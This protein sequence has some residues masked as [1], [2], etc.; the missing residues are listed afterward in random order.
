M[1]LF[2]TGQTRKTPQ[3]MKSNRGSKGSR[4]RRMEEEEEDKRRRF[5]ASSN[6]SGWWLVGG[7]DGW[8]DYWEGSLDSLERGL[9][10][11]VMYCNPAYGNLWLA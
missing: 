9:L 3:D 4:R 8:R 6:R 10:G 2:A 7:G 5:N 11:M 1:I